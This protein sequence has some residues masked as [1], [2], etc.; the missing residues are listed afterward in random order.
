MI[1]FMYPQE[2]LQIKTI[3]FL[4]KTIG[5]VTKTIVFL[6]KTIG[7]VTDTIV[8]LIKTIGLVINT[9]VF[10]IKTIGLVTDTIE[11]VIRRVLFCGGKCIAG[12]M[13]AGNRADTFVFAGLHTFC[14]HK[15]IHTHMNKPPIASDTNPS[16][17][18]DPDIDPTGM[19]RKQ[20]F[21]LFR[22]WA[23]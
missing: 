14:L 20:Q 10:L 6:I 2:V 19:L 21:I 15:T 16:E 13:H 7:L 22:Y 4:I 1:D 18:I 12:I 9:I 8:F 11:F 5:L 3:V 17:E 23:Y